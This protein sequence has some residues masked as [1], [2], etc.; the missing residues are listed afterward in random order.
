MHETELHGMSD[1]ML[2]SPSHFL[3]AGTIC[4]DLSLSQLCR[5]KLMLKMSVEVYHALMTYHHVLAT[6]Q[7]II[8]INLKCWT[9]I[10]VNP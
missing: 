7:F 1:Y 8:C 4:V 2:C 9:C 6:I 5:S 10:R 3:L